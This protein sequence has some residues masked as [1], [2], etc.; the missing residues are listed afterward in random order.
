MMFDSDDRPLAH[1]TRLTNCYVH[2]LLPYEMESC[3]N[4]RIF[5]IS[6]KDLVTNIEVTG[7]FL[8]A[9]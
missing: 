9:L 4:R 2:S 5:R 1:R 7:D 6:W 3:T 8:R